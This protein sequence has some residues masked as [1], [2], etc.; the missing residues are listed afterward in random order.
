MFEFLRRKP[1]PAVP[2]DE[3]IIQGY[4]QVLEQVG[5]AVLDQKLLPYPKA[6]IKAALARW[7]PRVSGDIRR[8]MEHGLITLAQFQPGVGEARYP[9]GASSGPARCRHGR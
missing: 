9:D 4:G 3:E 8:H 5:V 1:K 7:I 2:T 6:A